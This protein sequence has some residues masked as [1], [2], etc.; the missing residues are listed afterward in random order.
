VLVKAPPL[1]MATPASLGCTGH[2]SSVRGRSAVSARVATIQ[3][4]G[5]H[6]S[7]QA[8][9][10]ISA[11]PDSLSIPV[12]CCGRRT[13]FVIVLALQRL[14]DPLAQIRCSPLAKHVRFQ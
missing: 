6:L 13:Y 12:S 10:L 14:V 2:H 1:L 5:C 11:G 3:D 7:V 4:K 9:P 8:P